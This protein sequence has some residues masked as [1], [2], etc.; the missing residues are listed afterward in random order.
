MLFVFLANVVVEVVELGEHT[1][2]KRV[3]LRADLDGVFG[4]QTLAVAIDRDDLRS[5]SVEHGSAPLFDQINDL[6]EHGLAHFEN[7]RSRVIIGIERQHV[8]QVRLTGCGFLQQLF[9]I[10]VGGHLDGLAQTFADR[11][12]VSE[13]LVGTDIDGLDFTGSVLDVVLTEIVEPDVF[14][15]LAPTRQQNIA[16]STRIRLQGLSLLL[17]CLLLV[18]HQF[19][20]FGSVHLY[21]LSM[22]F[23]LKFG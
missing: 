21:F 22:Q 18:L 6:A 10:L 23:D 4:V 16:V 1:L 12:G 3:L 17:Q 8:E 2:R 9:G 13:G 19:H 11:A 14:L 7:L 5:F 20:Q 15:T